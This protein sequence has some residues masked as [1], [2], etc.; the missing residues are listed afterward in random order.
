MKARITELRAQVQR[1]GALGLAVWFGVFFVS[2]GL[3]SALVA[4]GV[5]W[6]WLTEKTGALG[7]LAAGYLLTKLLTLPRAALVVAITPVVA[8]RLGQKEQEPTG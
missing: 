7:P 8:R 1:Y 2:I 5:E 4:F 3:F 6:P